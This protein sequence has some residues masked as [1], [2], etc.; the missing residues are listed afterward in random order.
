MLKRIFDISISLL[1]IIALLFPSIILFMFIK[2]SSKESL[3]FWS[4]RVGVNNVNYWMPKLRTMRS[5]TPQKATHL[6]SNPEKYFTKY[7]S[8]LRK[9]SIDEIPQFYSILKGDMSLVG[10]RPALFN[11]Y[12]LI[13]LRTEKNLTYLLP[14]LT[15][16]AQI[17]G[18][19]NLTIEEKV[20]LDAEYAERKSFL[21]DLY[22]ILLT[23][24][25][26]INRD[27]ISH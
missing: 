10:P 13:K 15:G 1:M 16:W 21:F 19:D 4:Q 26:V 11:Q 2:S 12:D 7:G 20:L 17:N 25:N 14:G 8:A 9:F 23:I 27:K 24:K 5:E 3:L 18:R 6:M 22:I